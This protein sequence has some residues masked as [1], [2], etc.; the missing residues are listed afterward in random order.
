[1]PHHYQPLTTA[2][3]DRV[4]GSAYNDVSCYL[5]ETL[6]LMMTEKKAVYKSF[7]IRICSDETQQMRRVTVT[8]INET[9]EQHSF[10]CLDGLMIFLL[11]EMENPAQSTP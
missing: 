6:E 11:Q 4:M 9:G 7:L 1:M 3:N 10:T 5:N 8:R 2:G